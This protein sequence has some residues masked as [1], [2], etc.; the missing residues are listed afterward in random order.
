MLLFNEGDVEFKVQPLYIRKTTDRKSHNRIGPQI[1]KEFVLKSILWN[2]PGAQVAATWTLGQFDK[3]NES[4]LY[5]YF[6]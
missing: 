5:S 6:Y 3:I 1:D 4:R 2:M